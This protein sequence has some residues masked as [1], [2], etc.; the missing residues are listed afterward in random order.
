MII[1]LFGLGIVA[2]SFTVVYLFEDVSTASGFLRLLHWPAMILTGVGPIGLVMLCYD[3][4]LLGRSLKL[5]FAT[6]PGAGVR[7]ARRESLLLGKWGREYYEEGPEI[8]ERIRGRGLSD[9]VKTMI[10]RLVVRVPTRDIRE[11]LENER[12]HRRGRMFQCLNVVNLGVRLAPS[13]GMLG[14]ILGMVRLLSTLEDP[15]HIGPHMSLALLTT[16]YGLFFSLVVWTPVQQKI[17]RL[18]D[19]EL[20]HFNQTVAWLETLENRKPISYY[21]EPLGVE[22]PKPNSENPDSPEKAA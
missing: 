22:A 11:M 17:E 3:S 1:K 7:K 19:I 21:T 12:D 18:L 5:V 15:S 10:E 9:F 14:T 16:F 6:S 4:D 8:F 2:G 20:E 13:M